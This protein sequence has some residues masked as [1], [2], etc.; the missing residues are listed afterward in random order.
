MCEVRLNIFY[1]FYFILKLITIHVKM[2]N[3]M[4]ILLSV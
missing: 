2:Y 4:N 1:Y 3:K